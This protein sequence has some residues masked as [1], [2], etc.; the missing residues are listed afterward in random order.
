MHHLTLS[1]CSSASL[2][3]V[4][5]LEQFLSLDLRDPS[6]P[7]IRVVL[8]A[9]VQPTMSLYSLVLRGGLSRTH[10]LFSTHPFNDQMSRKMA[11]YAPFAAA[12]IY[13][14]TKIAQSGIV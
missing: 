7:C 9:G 13:P 6:D 5:T 2:G 11:T 8:D 10:R 4:N 14:T 1:R 12:D 3:V